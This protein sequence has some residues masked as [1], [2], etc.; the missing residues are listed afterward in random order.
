MVEMS[1]EHD[2]DHEEESGK[3]VTLSCNVTHI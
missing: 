2:N 3:N 1:M